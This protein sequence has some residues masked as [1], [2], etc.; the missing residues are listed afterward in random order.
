MQRNLS[1]LLEKGFNPYEDNTTNKERFLGKKPEVAESIETVMTQPT[2]TGNNMQQPTTTCNNIKQ[3]ETIKEMSISEAFKYGLNIKKRELNSN[4]Y[5]GYSSHINRF[6]K[7]LTEKELHNKGISTITKT[8][9]MEYLNSLLQVSS[10][11]NRN[12]Y[13]SSIS[14]LFTTLKITSLLKTTLSKRLKT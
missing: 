14:S 1:L 6:E 7:W 9:V 2:T 4:S 8:L 11:R 13:R 5:H 10:T 12:N 3:V